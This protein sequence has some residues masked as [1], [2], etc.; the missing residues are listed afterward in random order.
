VSVLRGDSGD[1]GAVDSMYRFRRPRT[2]E[3]V[4]HPR[5]FAA[6]EGALPVAVPDLG[7]VLGPGWRRLWRTSVGEFDVQMLLHMNRAPRA[8]AGAAGWGGGRSS[9]GGVARRLPNARSRA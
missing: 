3:Q 9:C 7:A 5:K 8:A 2:S 6:G 1:W 4:I